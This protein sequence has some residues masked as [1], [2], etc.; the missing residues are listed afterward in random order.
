MKERALVLGASGKVGE[1]VASSLVAEGWQ[2]SGA[3]RFSKPEKADRLRD[4]GIEPLVYDVTSGDPA[5][6][7]EVDAVFLEIWDP[8]RPDLIWPINFYGVGRVV[9]R[10]AGR[11][12]FVN[13]CTINVY[14]ERPDAPDE[15]APC[16]PNT[17]Y[18]RSRYSQERLIDYF[19]HRSGSKA[20]HVRYAHANTAD[21]GIIRR[22]AETI[23]RGES[24]GANP[25]AKMR[26]IGMEDFVRVTVNAWQRV[27]NPPVAVNCCGVRVWTQRELA[28]AIHARMGRG[29]VVFDRDAGGEEHSVQ[30]DPGRMVSWFGEPAVAQETLIDRVVATIDGGHTQDD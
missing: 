22:M 12:N 24:L 5:L 20:I 18:G 23:V 6:L 27:A 7:P 14:G 17:D 25:D 16:R 13:G 28:E 29:Q 1:G 21:S 8:S 15:D 19:C 11:A 4:K 3:A 2:V 30:A 9:E 26:V 10:Y